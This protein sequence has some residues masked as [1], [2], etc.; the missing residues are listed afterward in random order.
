MLVNCK[1]K[2]YKIN[3]H[4]VQNSVYLQK[5]KWKIKGKKNGSFGQLQIVKMSKWLHYGSDVLL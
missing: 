5:K 1:L 3:G 4:A 2:I